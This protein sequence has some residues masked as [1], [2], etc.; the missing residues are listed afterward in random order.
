MRSLRSAVVRWTAALLCLVLVVAVEQPALAQ[1]PDGAPSTL[2]AAQ[3]GPYGLTA[4]DHGSAARLAAECG[5]SVEIEAGRSP[6]QRQVAEPD[7]S[8]TLESYLR[9]QWARDA[10]GEWVDVDPQLVPDGAGGFTTAASVVDIEVSGGGAGALV[11]ATD[12]AG[13]WLSVTW[14]D[15]LPEP[16]VE[17]ASATFPGVFEGV[18]LRVT[19]GV[20]SF[21]YMLVVHSAEAA[22]VELADVGVRLAAEELEVAQ[23]PT[24]GVVAV[25]PDGEV[26]FGAPGAAMWD[27]SVAGLDIEQQASLAQGNPEW[28]ASQYRHEDDPQP[29][30]R[31]DLDLSLD[32]D[33][34][35]VLTDVEF[36]S[37]PSV[38]FP[39]TIDPTFSAAKTAWTVVADGQYSNTTWWDDNAWPRDG[40]GGR[41]RMGYDS[42]DG[43]S[44]RSMASFDVAGIGSS[45]V[46]S[47]ELG[48]RVRHVHTCASGNAS[49]RVFVEVG[50]S[51]ALVQDEVPTSWSSTSGGWFADGR[52]ATAPYPDFVV[53]AGTCGG[54]D[55][56]G[57]GGGRDMTV[58]GADLRGLLQHQA[59]S[60]GEVV[61]LGLDAY[62]EHSAARAT[63]YADS[64]ALTVN[65]TPVVAVPTDLS[66][67]GV[68]C[69]APAGSRVSGALPVLA[70]VP[71]NS[72][73][74]VV[75]EFEL[76]TLGGSQP[77]QSWISEVLASGEP[78][79]WQVAESL[80]DG[81][82]RWRMR[83][84]HPDS[85]VSSGWSGWCEFR[86]DSLVDVEPPAE[87]EE[88]MECPVTVPASGEELLEAA[89]ESMALLLAQVCDAEVEALSE[90]EFGMRVVARPDGNL[91]AE[92]YTMPRW[93]HDE[94]G[95]WA[96]VDPAFEADGQGRLVTSVAVSQVEVSAGG[97]ADPLVTAT[98]PDGG[99]VSLWWP[100]ELPTPV[101][102]GETV[103][104]PEVFDEVDLQVTAGVDG[105]SYVLVVKSAAAAVSPELAAVEVGITA[106]DGFDLLQDADGVVM[107]RDGA[108]EAVFSSPAAYM[109]D[110]SE[111]VAA[112]S[113][114][115]ISG[116]GEG[117]G[118]PEP[119]PGR[120]A[121]MPLDLDGGVLR[122]EPDQDLLSDP[123]VEFPV[124]I[125]PPFT[126]RHTH[127]ASVHQQ[128]AGRGW[129]DDSAW[130]RQGGMRVGR[131]G[132]WPNSQPCQDACG[133][134]R[135]AVR[136][137]INRLSGR[138]IVSAQVKLTQTHT[139]GC[140]TYGLQ[141]WYVTAITSGV[142]WNQM[143]SRWQNQLQSQNVA[144]SNSGCGLPNR[145]VTF[146][147]SAVRS[148]V[149]THANAGHSQ[150]SFGLRSTPE[151]SIDPYRRI[152][153]GSLALEVVYNQFAQM[154]TN[155][156]TDGRGCATSGP[157]PWLTTQRPTLSGVP[158]DPDGR[159]GAH[160]Q[161]R[162]IGSSATHYS[163]QTARN[164]NHNTV[165]NHRIP[166]SDRLSSGSYRWR[167]RSLDNLASAG[168]SDWRQWCYFRVDVTSPTAP[169]VE[170]VGDPPA[171]GDE[172]TLRFRSSDA[173]SGLDR[174]EFGINE[175][176]RR[177]QVSA[178]S[179]GT[180]E[181]TFTASESGGHMWVY[182]WSRD[183]AGNL[184]NRS[185]FDFYAARFVE[186]TPAAAWRLDGDAVDDSGQG[187]ELMF[188]NGADWEADAGLPGDTS[189]GFDG[190][191]C[192]STTAPVVRTDA[193]YTVSAWVRLDDNS[194][195][196][197]V[198]GPAGDGRMGFYLRYRQASDQWQ[199][200]LG[201]N[202]D[203]EQ[204]F[205]SLFSAQAP[206]V[207]QWTHITVR[208]DPA[209]RYMQMFIDGQLVDGR[210]IPWATWNATGPMYVGC[211]ARNSGYTWDYFDGAIHHVGVWQGL[212]TVDEIE[213]AY[214]GEL[215]AGLTGD[216]QLRGDGRDSS[217]HVRGV[218]VPTGVGFVDDQ[219]G[220]QRSA[221]QLPGGLEAQAQT[222][223]VKT[224]QAFSVAAWARLDDKGGFRTVVSQGG[225]HVNTFNLGYHGSLDRWQL[226]M[227]SNDAAAP[228]HWHHALSAGAPQV[229]QWYHLVGVF[230]PA[231]GRLRLYV[232]GALSGSNNGPAQPWRGQDTLLIGAG[233]T[234]D[235]SRFN[236]MVGAISDVKTWRGALT[237]EQAAHAYGGNPAVEWLS[238]W[239]LNGNGQDVRGNHP[240]TMVGT[241][242]VDY[243]W[244]SDQRCR[245]FHALGLH[246]SGAGHAVTSGPVVTTDES[247]T[248]TA[249]VKVDSIGGYQTVLSQAGQT[250]SAFYLQATPEGAWRFAMPQEDADSTAWVAADSSTG[251]VQE[252]QWTHL[253]GV[254]DLAAGEIRLYVDGQLEATGSGI[255]APWQAAGSLYIG[256]GLDDGQVAQ[257]LQ[258]AV[259]MATAW[260]S[261]VDPDRLLEMGRSTGVPGFC[262]F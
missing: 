242:G 108:G 76:R 232:D 5:E 87:F 141:L 147:A 199:F 226:S 3:E 220:R 31:V 215:P 211:S 75:A 60:S 210:A 137:N 113:G 260:S 233:G 175:E 151:S 236:H 140:G 21:A 163:W 185:V 135:S 14:P 134:W 17:G 239:N 64:L 188:G 83:S 167:M 238:Q 192:V 253:A 18:D 118:D 243:E 255:T 241:D 29:G 74:T 88:P 194:Q 250:R 25:D 40:F 262:P 50:R 70:G 189:L 47:A 155:L 214:Q 109:W 201:Q 176:V 85:G 92:Q 33:V 172:V 204:V 197:T 240:L 97:E 227:P 114:A 49:A 142:T 107:V 181:V 164:R 169:T 166:T 16:A 111:P 179:S 116:E 235:G 69:L 27:S 152:A 23:E 146:G 8:V 65:Y 22:A 30:Q 206:V 223:V 37:D 106:G 55:V 124:M 110:S 2:C 249:W 96:E 117:S 44:W 112:E 191:G 51:D 159:T 219:Y 224:D 216:W 66:T 34:L 26:V 160:L 67:G 125:D 84:E 36:L 261:T 119:T 103:T 205:A 95:E 182:V 244:V 10:A 251:A 193:E 254:F 212:R 230:D 12:Q 105:F 156:S 61:T 77:L 94:D 247:F 46:N 221:M 15:T 38:A 245:P 91:V 136:F 231:A 200:M 73:G 162:R 4:G 54:V 68:G 173:H 237:D 53:E 184:S 209:A 63:G 123:D 78:V 143:Q 207:G 187:H 180:A 129:T 208:V 39:V 168:A 104:Y 122:V 35:H 203:R 71:R 41:I 202:D 218:E 128:Q 195:R 1:G 138:H 139:S 90:R 9:P 102:D 11:R 127:W 7:G 154:P 150:L 153:P 56:I 165:V 157:G 213:A 82:Y 222:P 99:S 130:P 183:N 115:G 121:Q 79:G 131:L 62:G 177:Q 229:G 252:G 132:N 248:V 101:V 161:I 217:D 198:M 6:T 42:R 190:E 98:D 149:Q 186:A 225:E 13:R 258:G 257:N 58:G 93:A 24:G 80:P 52:L 20:D 57:A 196:Q 246:L 178:S 81:E 45:V 126:G 19:A 228:A 174:F 145:G 43:L 259:D 170:V 48:L 234:A 28:G 148:R 144:S 158:R 59:D 133:L 120:I 32:G 100:D 171:A 72:E 256:A 89:D 86:V